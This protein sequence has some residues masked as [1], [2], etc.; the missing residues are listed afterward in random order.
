MA[1]GKKQAETHA[2]EECLQALGLLATPTKPA[3]APAA[4]VVTPEE[5]EKINANK[6]TFKAE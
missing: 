6:P 2:A 5:L 1:L 4:P 3:P